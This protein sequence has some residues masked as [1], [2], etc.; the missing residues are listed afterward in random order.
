MNFVLPGANVR[1]LA[2]TVNCFSKIGNELFFEATPDGLELKTINATNTAYAVAQFKQDFFISF[3]QGNADTPDENCCKISVK[4]ILKIF[5]SLSTIQTCK[6]WLDIAHSKIIFQ[7]RCKSEVLKT[8]KIF[9]LESEHINSLNLSQTFPS[10]IIA[11]HK[12][13]SNMLLHLHHS[14][15]EVTFDLKE[16]KAVVSNFVDNEQSD[17]STLRSALTVD[18]NTFQLYKLDQKASLTFCYKE[19]KA[20]TMFASF[21]RLDIQMSFSQAGSPLMIQMNKSGVV[22]LKVILGTMQPSPHLYNRRVHR[23]NDSKRN[24]ANRSVQ[25]DSEAINTLLTEDITHNTETSQDVTSSAIRLTANDSDTR[26]NFAHRNNSQVSSNVKAKRTVQDVVNEKLQEDSTVARSSRSEVPEQLN[27]V[28]DRQH[29]STGKTTL[30]NEPSSETLFNTNSEN[31]P[32][33]DGIH[34]PTANGNDLNSLASV[35]VAT[36]TYKKAKETPHPIE[37]ASTDSDNDLC[38]VGEPISASVFSRKRNATDNSPPERDQRPKKNCTKPI[39]EIV[40][41]SPEVIEERKRKQ[42]KLRHI[43]RR[44]FEPTFDPAMQ[45]GCSQIFAANSDSEGES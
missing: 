30:T 15:D 29:K 31:F 40:P 23:R 37:I 10:E 43:F 12:A 36:G 17:R 34:L 32:F 18:T 9:L 5:K 8:H 11:N 42:A 41:E 6:I 26:A 27:S 22:Q 33:L 35:P 21:T 44:C 20:I 4:P 2:R 45:P 7:F 39:A 38:E 19:F 28:L 14:I 16:D 3:Q 24:T 1:M 13:F 25:M